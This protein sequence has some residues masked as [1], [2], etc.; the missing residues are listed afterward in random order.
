MIAPRG[1]VVSAN[2]ALT[3]NCTTVESLGDIPIEELVLRGIKTIFLEEWFMF[4]F[5]HQRRPISGLYRAC[6]RFLSVFLVG[7]AKEKRYGEC[8]FGVSTHLSSQQL[9]NGSV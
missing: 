7:C 9:E 8:L 2:V 6:R 4:G 3:P 1:Y 5:D